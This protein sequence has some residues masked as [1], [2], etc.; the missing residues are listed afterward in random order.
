MMNFI[1]KFNF[2]NY[3]IYLTICIFL[4]GSLYIPIISSF[5]QDNSESDA[6]IWSGNVVLTEDF[7]IQKNQTLII[8]PGTT[9]N[10]GGWVSI[11]VNGNLSAVGNKREPIVFTKSGE[12]KWRK[13]EVNEG[14]KVVLEHCK[15]EENSDGVTCW[16]NSSVTIKNCNISST[17][18][19]IYCFSSS[20]LIEGNIITNSACAICIGLGS[21]PLIRNNTLVNNLVGINI[22]PSSSPTITGNIIGNNRDWGI[23][24]SSENMNIINNRFDFNGLPNGKGR[25]LRECDLDVKVVDFFGFSVKGAIVSVYNILNEKEWKIK[26]GEWEGLPDGFA[27]AVVRVYFIDNNGTKIMLTPHIIHVEKDG[28]NKTITVF[29]DKDKEIV[30]RLPILTNLSKTLIVIIIS[31]IIALSII[32]IKA[33]KKQKSR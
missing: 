5:A 9:V 29:M 10:I 19:A 33:R 3:K 2:R 24:T 26:T 23:E 4:L 20:P 27:G 14:S 8:K 16:G 17:A 31:A 32:F 18:G 11:I 25:I 22:G 30:V 1:R 7:L 21:S 12:R 15:I 6:I 13:I 28:I